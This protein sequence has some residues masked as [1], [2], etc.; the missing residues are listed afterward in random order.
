MKTQEPIPGTPAVLKLYN[1][2]GDEFFVNIVYEVEESASKGCP[3]VYVHVPS[4]YKSFEH[5]REDV[6]N[7]LYDENIR[8]TEKLEI[9]F[10]EPKK[11]K[12]ISPLYDACEKA[13]NNGYNQALLDV[14]EFMSS[15]ENVVRFGG[16]GS[17]LY[18]LKFKILSLKKV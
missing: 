17:L 14:H 15:P 2:E 10:I 8:C 16:S 18:D 5:L 6:I 12:P 9:Y 13:R 7:F 11:E 1:Y 4:A 3:N